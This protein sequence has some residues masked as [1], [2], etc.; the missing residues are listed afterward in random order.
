MTMRI[1]T[2]ILSLLDAIGWVF[3]ARNTL[4]SESDPATMGLDKAAGW[5]V[6]ILLL[7]TAVPAF[8]LALKNLRPKTALALA[9]VFPVGIGALVTAAALYFTY[10]M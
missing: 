9:L 10:L 2:I 7:L 5:I 3:I 6:T 8:V 4:F 1:V